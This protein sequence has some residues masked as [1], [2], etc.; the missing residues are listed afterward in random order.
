MA[1]LVENDVKP[2]QPINAC[3]IHYTHNILPVMHDD[4]GESCQINMYA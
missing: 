2:N 1:S 4:V 3:W